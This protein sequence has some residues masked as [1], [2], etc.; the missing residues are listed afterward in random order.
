[1]TEIK[2]E[3]SDVKKEQTE[4]PRSSTADVHAVD[5]ANGK[6]EEVAKDI[7]K[8]STP[9]ETE[10]AEALNEIMTAIYDCDE[11]DFS[12]EDFDFEDPELESLIENFQE[13]KW[14]KLTYM[15][16]LQLCR[17]LSYYLADKLGIKPPPI[18]APFVDE[19]YHCGYYNS[20]TNIIRV[21]VNLFNNS[22]E[23]LDTIAHETWHAYQH[24]CA[25]RGETVKDVLYA[26]NFKYYITTS[27][28]A[29]GKTIG[30]NEYQSQL[31]EAE[32]RA[33]ANQ[34]KEKVGY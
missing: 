5:G 21:N 29:N 14:E 28:D 23:T 8:Q 1:M 3:V 17:S 15:E 27:K 34:I 12:F 19:P 30:F 18:V 26:Y 9:T 31:V 2:P 32:A 10:L 20:S 4:L 7:E 25:D 33:F 13:E 24:K 22:K 11:D 6:F 16:R